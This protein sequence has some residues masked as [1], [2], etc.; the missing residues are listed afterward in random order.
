MNVEFI[1]FQIK[2][3]QAPIF[4]QIS[5]KRARKERNKNITS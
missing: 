5:P 1:F 2:A 3:L 4:A